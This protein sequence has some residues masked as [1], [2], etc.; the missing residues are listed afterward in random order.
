MGESSK[1]PP[2]AIWMRA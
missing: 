2:P 1:L